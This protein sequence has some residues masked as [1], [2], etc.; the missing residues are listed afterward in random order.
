MRLWTVVLVLFLATLAGVIMRQDPGYA[1]FSYGDWTLEMPLW[2]AAVLLIVL[3]ALCLFLLWSLNT[4]FGGGPRVKN[5]WL[6]KKKALARN[7]TIQGLLELTEGHWQKAENH[8]KDAARF[9]D[10]PLIN[11]LAAAK[12]AG[13]SGAYDR[14]D[15]YLKIAHD[16]SGSAAIPVRLI[17]A[18]LSF[19][20]GDVEK[21]TKALQNLYLEKPKHP[22]VLR[23]LSQM[24]EST[25]NWAALH[26]LLPALKKGRIFPVQKAQEDLEQK[27]CLAL[28]PMKAKEG[29][30]A[31]IH[32]WKACPSTVQNTQDAIRV[33]TQSLMEV[34]AHA[35]AEAFSR[36]ILKKHWDP[37]LGRLYGKI[38]GP[39]IQKQ[40]NF[41]ETLLKEHPRDPDLLFMLGYLSF[42][43][44]LWG[45][46]KDYLEDSIALKPSAE[47]YALLGQL[48]D[49]L[50]FPAK[51]DEYYKKGLFSY[52]PFANE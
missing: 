1:L 39:H 17:E 34:G 46:A 5:W 13:E 10:A 4:F 36:N 31:L 45:K 14:R 20:Q 8:L 43:N 11:Y 40:L 6:T 27:V 25:K 24:Y 9:S 23:L 48:M 35:E 3:V 52:I 26:A 22:E 15:R 51:R 32:F 12:A 33:Y 44:Q 29:Q 50:G 21:S 37:E 16:L 38:K 2:L 30:D 42:Q 19:Q 18:H 49:R 28:L 41:A 7:N 47:A